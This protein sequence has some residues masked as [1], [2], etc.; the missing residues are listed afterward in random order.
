M[1]VPLQVCE[2]RDPKGLYKLARAGKIKGILREPQC[3]RVLLA[4]L[5]VK[6]SNIHLYLTGFT[7]IDDP[8]EPPLDAE[9]IVQSKTKYSGQ[10]KCSRMHCE[11]IHI[12]LHD[13]SLRGMQCAFFLSFGWLVKLINCGTPNLV[14]PKA[15]R[16]Q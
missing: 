3:N 13:S 10:H 2:N 8:Y 12:H 5:T 7:G 1:D 11:N 16:K 6:S 4:Y 15:S 14:L 9:V